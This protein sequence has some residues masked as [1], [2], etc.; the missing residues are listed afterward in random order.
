M[1]QA[2]SS[3]QIIFRHIRER[4]EDPGLDRG[5]GLCAG[6]DYQKG[7]ETGAVAARNAPNYQ[8]PTFRENPAKTSTYGKSLCF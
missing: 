7:T 4:R 1:D 2:A 5:I 6:R 3:N 8:H